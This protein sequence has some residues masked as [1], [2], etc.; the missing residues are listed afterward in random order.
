MS[1]TF[2]FAAREVLV[3]GGTSGIGAAVADA[4]TLA[5]AR[6]TITGTRA[7]S[8]AYDG[9]PR[10]HRYLPLRLGERKNVLDVADAC[11]NID[12][13]INNAGRTSMP[14]DFDVAVDELLKGTHALTMAC[15][16]ALSRS[17]QRG[18]GAV[19]SLASMMAFFGNTL[20]PGYGAAKAGLLMLT[21]SLAQG[22]G[23]RNVRVN[24]VAPGAIRTPMT[25]R[26]ADDPVYG[27]ATAQRIA[28]G[29]WGEPDDIAD[30]IL[31]LASPAARYITGECLAVSGGYMIA[32]S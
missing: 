4:F 11:A 29:R 17:T 23:D 6:V 16:P 3:T 20:F 24:A 12:V 30:P 14:E 10:H 1:T 7:D 27:P 5:G 9:L 31:F 22:W 8:A 32:D 13:L 19:I 21:R 28:L 26:F 25:E 18:G 15:L 2:D